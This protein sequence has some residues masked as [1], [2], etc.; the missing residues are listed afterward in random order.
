[1][2]ASLDD[3]QLISCLDLARSGRASKLI[4]AREYPLLT[5]YCT[6]TYVEPG[7]PRAIFGNQFRPLWLAKLITTTGAGVEWSRAACGL[8][9]SVEVY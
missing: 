5:Y 8:V 4:M 1:M 7:Y 2:H 9:S 3:P 6:R